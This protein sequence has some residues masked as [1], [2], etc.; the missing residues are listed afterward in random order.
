MHKSLLQYES[1]EVGTPAA[2]KKN[3][4]KQ[5]KLVSEL[6]KRQEEGQ[7]TLDIPP[8]WMQVRGQ[9]PFTIA[10]FPER[11]Y[12]RTSR[13]LALLPIGSDNEL[14]LM[15][16]DDGTVAVL[17][18]D[19]EPTMSWDSAG[20][21]YNNSL[22]LIESI[23]LE[24]GKLLVLPGT[25]GQFYISGKSKTYLVDTTHWSRALSN[26]IDNSDLQPI[27]GLDFKSNVVTFD[28]QHEI[29]SCALWNKVGQ[30]FRVFMSDESV[31]AIPVAG[32]TLD[33]S[34]CKSI[35]VQSGIS[36]YKPLFTQP[37]SEIMALNATFQREAKRPLSKLIDSSKRQKPLHNESSEDQLDILTD[38]SKEFLEKVSIGQSLGLMMH[39]RFVEQQ[40]ELA[41]QLQHSSVIL[42]K[43]TNLKQISERQSSE[44]DAK[45]DR[46]T[47][48]LERFDKLNESLV[49]I[50]ESPKFRDMAINDK[51]IAWFKEIRNQVFAFNQYVHQ[52]KR[53]QDQ[54]G[55]VRHE[56]DQIRQ[57]TDNSDNFNSEWKELL[58]ILEN[59]TKIIRECNHELS[60]THSEVGAELSI[61][62]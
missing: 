13:Q 41:R 32:E 8:E 56:L 26:C 45:S 47:K 20:Y 17:Y 52:Q 12:D 39:G 18:R 46:Q 23:K 53:L 49:R 33:K 61:R 25:K 58:T 57:Q 51:E 28:F 14:L 55:Y 42:E 2:T 59:D 21:T 50:S 37:L 35:D 9:G 60:Q 15:S 1:L 3:T 40:N 16:L 44:C 5:F 11:Y 19:L 31:H 36:G 7:T 10:P 62:N 38:L 48:I 27:A 54:L 4:L 29:N 6:R 24:A 30:S 43:Q 22:V 34:D